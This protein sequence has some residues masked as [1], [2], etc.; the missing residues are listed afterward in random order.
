MLHLFL[1]VNLMLCLCVES[2]PKDKDR[3]SSDDEDLGT[4][5]I[6]ALRDDANLDL[7]ADVEYED[8]RAELLAY[9]TALA[10]LTNQSRS[11]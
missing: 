2:S 9:H 1:L 10:S 6:S 3:K 4:G 11:K 7:S 8:L 5:I